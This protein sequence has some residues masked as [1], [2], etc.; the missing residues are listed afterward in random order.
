MKA[1]LRSSVLALIVF[2]GYA[3]VVTDIAHQHLG[4]GLPQPQCIPGVPG[5]GVCQ[6]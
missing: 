1:L 4:A 2:A 5:A 3:A 6:K